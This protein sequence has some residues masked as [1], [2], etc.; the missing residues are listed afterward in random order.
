MTKRIHGVTIF[1]LLVLISLPCSAQEKVK[2]PVAASTK[3]LS[4]APLWVALR[5]GFYDQQG[6]DVQLVT[7]RGS[8]LTLQ[9]LAAGSIYVG[10]ATTDTTLGSVD[11]GLD[12]V[13]IGGLINGINMALV[14]AKNYKTYADL[15]G[16]TIGSLTLTSGTGFALRLVLKAH[17]LEFPRDYTLLNIGG[18]SDRFTAL[19]SGQIAAAPMGSPLDIT[20]EERGFNIIGRFIDDIPDYQL[21][22]L[23]VS[24]FWAARNKNLLVR[25]VKAMVLANRW[26]FEN[27]EA[28]VALLAKEMQ[29]NPEHTRKGWEYSVKNRI[30]DP[31]ANINMK[32]VETIIKIYGEIN[33]LKGPLPSPA[34][35]IDLTYLK[36]ALKEIGKK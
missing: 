29:L 6:L 17:G 4:Y 5:Q 28:A 2:F 23:T 35:Y 13:M 15:R 31:D 1:L 19:N 8:P 11:K 26:L 7:M 9:A 25:F 32:G 10:A 14:G 16:A 3:T 24:R 22:A 36:E 27:R 20:A 12:L 18:S 34:R 33:Q 21:N 30:W